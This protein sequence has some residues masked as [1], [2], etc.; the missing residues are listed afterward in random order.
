M[1]FSPKVNLDQVKVCIH[2]EVN[3]ISGSRDIS[4][5]KVQDDDFRFEVPT[6][7]TPTITPVTPT[8]FRDFGQTVLDYQAE[9]ESHQNEAG[10]VPP[11]VQAMPSSH[12][13]S[14]NVP[15]TTS[16]QD[17]VG[18]SGNL[19]VS[20]K[21]WQGGG[22][23]SEIPAL[24]S[25]NS[26]TLSPPIPTHVISSMGSASSS[27]SSS[28][29]RSRRST[30]GRRPN[31]ENGISPEEEEKK[32]IRRDRNK[33]AAA[34]CRLKRVELIK[35]LE[36]AVQELEMKRDDIHQQNQLLENEMEELRAIWEA[37]A[38]SCRARDTDS[39]E[40]VKPF[41]L[42]AEAAQ[43]H[44]L[45]HHLHHQQQQQHQHQHHHLNSVAM[46]DE[47]PAALSTVVVTSGDPSASN[48][49]YTSMGCASESLI[50]PDR[51]VIDTSA[52]TV[53]TS[54]ASSLAISKLRPTSL[55]LTACSAATSTSTSSSSFAVR[56]K[57]SIAEITGIP[58]T[59]PSAEFID[60]LIQSGSTGLTPIST[61]L[62]PVSTIVSC[63]TQLRTNGM[64]VDLSS[65][66]SIPSASKLVSL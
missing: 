21:S 11:L 17:S 1:K 38:P 54:S 4:K 58:I 40:D 55:P 31:K 34:K 43:Q 28:S 56:N 48:R 26:N 19:Y 12:S 39:P 3:L 7:T 45:P 44:L 57:N 32:R 60:S 50:I 30:G 41:Q 23:A 13:S 33:V 64:V 63:S 9:T 5:N 8:T 51:I 47:K 14:A 42:S 37:H 16:I 15:V 22:S 25:L 24:L 10:F 35:T 65:P 29:G 36:Q 6:K 59:T 52:T 2:F 49:I 61:G 53:A 18:C 62:T 66:D 46:H 27:S 20:M